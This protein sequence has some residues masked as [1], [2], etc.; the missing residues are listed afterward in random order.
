MGA[1]LSG[2]WE[3]RPNPSGWVFG[4]QEPQK[5]PGAGGA[6]GTLQAPQR[7]QAAA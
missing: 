5:I 2:V 4:M 6:L 1:K 7:E 3:H